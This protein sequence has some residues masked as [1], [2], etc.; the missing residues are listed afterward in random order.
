[1]VLLVQKGIDNEKGLKFLQGFKRIHKV[2]QFI[3]TNKNKIIFEI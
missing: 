2:S 1:M 3:D